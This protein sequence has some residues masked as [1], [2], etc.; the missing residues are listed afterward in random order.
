M[1]LKVELFIER[2]VNLSMH[3]GWLY[4]PALG[5]GIQ[6][7]GFVMVDTTNIALVN[8]KPMTNH[9]GPKGCELYFRRNPNLSKSLKSLPFSSLPVFK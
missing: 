4:H 7:F 8:N 2:M 1:V 3:N 9:G 5:L 6:L